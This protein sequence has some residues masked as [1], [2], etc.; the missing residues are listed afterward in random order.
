MTIFDMPPQLKGDDSDVPALRN[1]L[2]RINNDFQRLSQQIE[3]LENEI[4]KL[5]E[6][7]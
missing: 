6:N 5:K 1:Y 2:V 3:T 7:K 4:N